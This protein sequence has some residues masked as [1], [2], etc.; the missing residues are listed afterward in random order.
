M[1][2]Y[3]DSISLQ[4]QRTDMSGSNTTEFQPNTSSQIPQHVVATV[5]L[6]EHQNNVMSPNDINVS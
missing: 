2:L 3:I 4:S 5:V 1:L 6:A